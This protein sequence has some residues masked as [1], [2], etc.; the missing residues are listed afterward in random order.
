MCVCVC[1]G[2]GGEGGGGKELKLISC[3]LKTHVSFNHQLL[4]MLP[5]GSAKP[6]RLDALPDL[7]QLQ[8]QNKNV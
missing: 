5:M 3:P 2:L 7:S 1:G 8:S 4:P 6:I